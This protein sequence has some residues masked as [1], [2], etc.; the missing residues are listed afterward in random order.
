MTDKALDAAWQVFR[1]TLRDTVAEYARAHAPR[2]ATVPLEPT[3]P[4]RLETIVH[5][6]LA[7]LERTSDADE[8]SPVLRAAR[9]AFRPT[10]EEKYRRRLKKAFDAYVRAWQAR[11]PA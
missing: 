3:D 5:G 8:A 4:E 10:N 2:I 9:R 1:F 6:V 11:G 7:E